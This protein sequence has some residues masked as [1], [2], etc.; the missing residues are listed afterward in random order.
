MNSRKQTQYNA[1]PAPSGL[2][3]CKKL[4]FAAVILLAV[5]AAMEALLALT[6]VKAAIATHDPYVGFRSEVPLFTKERDRLGRLIYQ[7]A[8]NK[9]LLFNQQSFLA[10]KD[11]HTY[12][13]FCMGGSTTHG[14]PYRDK[15]SFAGW[16]RLFLNAADPSRT[17]EVINCGGVSYASYRVAGLMEELAR[18]EPDLFIIYSGHNEFLERRTYS[19]IIEEHP[20]VTEL[21]LLF[22]RSR[23]AS[24]MRS[25]IRSVAPGR[26]DAAREQ[27]LL[28]GEVKTLLDASAGLDLYH[29]D[30][31]L[32][33]QILDHYRFN[34]G[35]MVA[36]AR[37]A[38]ADVIFIQPAANLKDFS[39]F[40]SEHRNDLTGSELRAWEGFFRDALD[41]MS[42][43]EYGRARQAFENAMAIDD[44]YAQ[45]HYELGRALFAPGGG[46]M[47][48]KEP[49]SVRCKRT[50]VHCGCCHRCMRL[51]PM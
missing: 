15:T 39:P 2:S 38:G 21:Q 43:G 51:W 32:R 44:R 27:Y 11:R 4:L 49:S 10:K 34:L 1:S 46:A 31:G 41:A 40:K 24:L 19:G 18:Y 6:G 29:R 8:Q 30:E 37:S 9:R 36:I 25:G 33:R 48:L 35:R 26:R 13:I 5:P 17:W 22:N 47:P 7:T 45:L 12:R 50:S 3:R 16:L 23:V 20:V 42:A 28:T 14:R